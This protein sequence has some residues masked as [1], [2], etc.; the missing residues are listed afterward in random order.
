VT[1]IRP[2]RLL[3]LAIGIGV[4]FVV[5]AVLGAVGIGSFI[6]VADPLTAADVIFVLEG[7]TPARELEAAALY[8]R[9]LAPRVVVSLGRDLLKPHARSLAGE[10]PTQTRAARVLEH[11]GVPASGIVRLTR[12]IDNTRQEL[13]VDF[14]YARAHGFRNVILVTSPVH[15]RR[16]RV[17][18]DA[19]CQASV[20]AA[21]HPTSFDSFD[22]RRW[23]S[24]THNVERT[25]HELAGIAHF[26]IGSP[27]PTY[28]R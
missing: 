22:P 20:P 16:V 8:H 18:W 10:A 13:K 14:D 21:V 3:V 27:L 9:G 17:I 12:E 15:T 6:E 25:L 19:C 26:L 28:G 5:L 7:G 1:W 23:W 11:A 24:S 2:R 4:A